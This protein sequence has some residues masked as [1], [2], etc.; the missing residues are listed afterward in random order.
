SMSSLID[1]LAQGA[2]YHFQLVASNSAG[3][4]LGGDLTFTTPTPPIVTTLPATGV[5]PASVTLNAAVNPNGAITAAYFQYGLTTNYDNVGPFISLPAT[6]A[7]LDIPGLVV[8]SLRGPAGTNW[9]S[10]SAPT[11]NWYS[12]AASA[13]GTRLAAVVYGGG[14]Y[15]STNG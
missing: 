15:T 8:T 13:D 12:I 3:L 6:N 5:T 4:S 10:A 7:A 9:T 14:I 1:G 2:T 11:N